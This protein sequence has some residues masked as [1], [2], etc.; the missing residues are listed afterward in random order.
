[1]MNGFL[2]YIKHLKR[3]VCESIDKILLVCIWLLEVAKCDIISAL[4]IVS[5]AQQD[6]ATA[7]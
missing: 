5:V 1:M 2:E 7:S 6:R 3:Y 4:P